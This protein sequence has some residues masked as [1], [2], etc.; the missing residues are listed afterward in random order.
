MVDL[1]IS[2]PQIIGIVIG[3]SVF[4]F[5][6]FIVIV[7]DERN[8]AESKNPHGANEWLFTKWD[9]KIYDAMTHEQPEVFLTKLGVDTEQYIKNCEVCRYRSPNLKKTAGRKITGLFIVALGV[10]FLMVGNIVGYA[11][12]VTFIIAGMMMYGAGISKV[13]KEAKQKK[14]QLIDEMPRFLDL[15]QTA[16]YINMPVEDAITVTCKHL[17]GTIISDELLSSMAESQIGGVSWQK[18]LENVARKYEVDAF[19]DFVLYL[20]TGYE[21]GLSIYDVVRRQA[22]EAQKTALIN[23]EG[24]ASKLNTSILIPITIFKLIPLLIIAALPVLLQM[25]GTGNLF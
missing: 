23:A 20:V 18:A 3:I 24:A 5:A 13:D 14:K 15:L 7:N 22:I 16:L 12:S 2:I 10:P 21:K 9:E 4:L 8:N 11:L 6:L 1:T 25:I 17:Y 19:S